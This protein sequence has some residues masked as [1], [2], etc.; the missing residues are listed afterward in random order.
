[1]RS[2]SSFSPWAFHVL[3]CFLDELHGKKKS[4]RKETLTYR[5]IQAYTGMK[6]PTTIYK[7]L[8]YLSENSYIL[9]VEGSETG[10]YRLNQSYEI[11]LDCEEATFPENEMEAEENEGGFPENGKHFPENGKGFPEN[12]KVPG[13]PSYRC[14]KDLLK[15]HVRPI[16]DDDKSCT[17]VQ[18]RNVVVPFERSLEAP[19]SRVIY[20]P[21]ALLEP[22]KALFADAGVSATFGATVKV[23][24]RLGATPDLIAEMQRWWMEVAMKGKPDATPMRPR[25]FESNWPRFMRERGAVQ[26]V[27]QHPSPEEQEEIKRKREER[28]EADTQALIERKRQNLIA[29]GKLPAPH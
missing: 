21:P 16:D 18:P 4:E 11:E 28:E 8:N 20:Q 19:P 24:E 7:M 15:D 22:L 29:A 26:P 1:M 5:D 6:S 9:P 14:S 27:R 13:V 3:V 17:R 25:Q 10:L 2:V 23:A 12:G